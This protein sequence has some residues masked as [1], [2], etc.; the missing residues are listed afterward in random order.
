MKLVEK[1]ASRLQCPIQRK[2]EVA[3]YRALQWVFS[4]IFDMVELLGY[5]PAALVILL[6]GVCS[7]T[8]KMS[9]MDNLLE[10]NT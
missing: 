9:P 3:R 8:Q 10:Y 2:R 7:M 4:S 5:Q 1:K 6:P